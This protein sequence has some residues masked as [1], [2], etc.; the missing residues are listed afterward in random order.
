[1]I[2]A[3]LRPVGELLRDWRQR[4]RLSQM[5]LA[6]QVE[7]STRHLSCL[8]TGR[9]TPSRAMLMRLAQRLDVPLR[10]RNRLMLAAGYAPLYTERPLDDG[11][12]AAVREAMAAV[13][14]GHEPYPALAIDRRWQLVAANDA[15][16]RLL[17]GVDPALLEPPVNVLR[18]SLHPR[19]LAP[20]IANLAQWRGHLFERLGGQLAASGDARLAELLRELRDYPGAGAETAPAPPQAVVVPLQLDTPAGALSLLGTTTVFGM[21]NDVTLSEL[22]LE[23][24]YPADTATGER[25]RALAR[26]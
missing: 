15:T 24:F 11:A 9:A 18:V 19:G 4:R 8:E 14:R 13:L 22:A 16:R 6:L 5:E 1:M 7:V 17:A 2:E 25:L 12:M 21:P 3:D 26:G 20:R 23:A 10:E